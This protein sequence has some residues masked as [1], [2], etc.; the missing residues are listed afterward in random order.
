MPGDHGWLR[1]AI[2]ALYD[3]EVADAD[4]VLG[5]ILEA[6]DALPSPPIVVLS[7]DHGEELLE[8]GGIGHASTTL[9][10]HPWPELVDVPLLIRFPDHHRAGEQGVGDVQQIDLLPSLL[11]LLGLAP[12]PASPGVPLDGRDLSAAWRS[13]APT[14]TPPLLVHSS[15][16]GWQCPPDRADERVT[17][18]FDGDWIRCGGACPPAIQTRLDAAEDRRRLL[19]TPVASP[20]A[21]P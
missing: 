20:R 17:A 10:S 18:L 19:G 16:C 9:A 14:P 12:E 8:R 4:A 21:S 7:A 6:V 15:P 13:G 3:A 1:P 5:R 2:S 11:P